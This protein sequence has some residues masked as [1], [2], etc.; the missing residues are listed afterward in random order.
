[1]KRISLGQWRWEGFEVV[2]VAISR[3]NESFG[4]GEYR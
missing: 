4:S 3:Y 2:E 1:M